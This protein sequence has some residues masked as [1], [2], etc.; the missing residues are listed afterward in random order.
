MALFAA[1]DAAVELADEIF[2]PFLF[3]ALGLSKPLPPSP[4]SASPSSAEQTCRRELQCSRHHREPIAGSSAVATATL[5]T[6]TKTNLKT[7][8]KTLILMTTCQPRASP[9]PAT[10]DAAAE[11]TGSAPAAA[12]SCTDSTPLSPTPPPLPLPLT[13]RLT[14]LTSSSQRPSLGQEG[15]GRTPSTLSAIP[16]ATCRES[17]APEL[18][19]RLALP[20]PVSA[21]IAAVPLQELRARP[22]DSRPWPT[23]AGRPSCLYVWH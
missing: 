17:F 23:P 16:P 15:R 19:P 6:N 7:K 3:P 13:I 18:E 10:A 12:I 11:T 9:T 20:G 2:P 1:L 4:R 5:N 14:P 8:P 22:R 21:A